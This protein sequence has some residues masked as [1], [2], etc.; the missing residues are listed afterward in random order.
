MI[1]FSKMCYDIVRYL[2]AEERRENVFKK[3]KPMMKYLPIVNIF[4]FLYYL[5]HAART[6]RKS[7]KFVLFV[8]LFGF[9]ASIV[10]N[11]TVSMQNPMIH[12]LVLFYV[13]YIMPMIMCI[14]AEK[15]MFSDKSETRDSSAN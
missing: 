9:S 14:A 10:Q 5:I 6:I 4:A 11:I 15:T 13:C 2:M 3:L 12:W 7:F 8:F 1:Y